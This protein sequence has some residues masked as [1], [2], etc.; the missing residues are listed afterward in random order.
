M[1]TTMLNYDVMANQFLRIALGGVAAMTAAL[2][3]AALH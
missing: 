2:V 1:R 3:I